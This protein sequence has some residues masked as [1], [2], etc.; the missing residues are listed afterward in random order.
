MS[1]G[2]DVVKQSRRS[3]CRRSHH[4]VGKLE[5]KIRGKI[6]GLGEGCSETYHTA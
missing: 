1:K 2:G 3:V 5:G 6:A 4:F